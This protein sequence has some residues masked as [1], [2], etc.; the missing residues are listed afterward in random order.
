MKDV[1]IK[2][3]DLIGIIMKNRDEHREI[4]LAAQKKYREI[5]ITLLDEKLRTAREGKPFVLR[6]IV[7]LVEPVDHTRDYDRALQMLD[8]EVEAIVVLSTADFSN[9]V[10]DQ[11]QWSHQWAVSNSRY[12]DS[13]KFR[14]LI[15]E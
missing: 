5:V 4:F 2:K 11:W 7:A 9:L 10:Q 1:R 12:T 13:P 6:E 3:N 8:L 15:D 14:S